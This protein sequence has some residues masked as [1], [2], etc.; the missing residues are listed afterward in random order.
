MKHDDLLGEECVYGIYPLVMTNIARK[1][2]I[3]SCS[4][5]MSLREIHVIVGYPVVR[6]ELRS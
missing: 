3:D 4:I 5:V 6:R 1:I 2:A